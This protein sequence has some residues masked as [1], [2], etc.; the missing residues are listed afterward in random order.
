MNLISK[1]KNLKETPIFFILVVL[2]ASLIGLYVYFSQDL[3][4]PSGLVEIFTFLLKNPD[5]YG[6]S[7]LTGILAFLLTYL[8]I[9]V[10]II[11][12]MIF[13]EGD[14]LDSIII[15]IFKTILPIILFIV[16]IIF[17]KG[18]GSIT[19]GAALAIGGVY[20]FMNSN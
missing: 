18:I 3:I 8:L 9:I 7:L 6:L 17:L 12:V 14:S 11:N 20:L 10:D 5:K 13:I 15:F 16:S 1:L 19:F 4:K 2:D